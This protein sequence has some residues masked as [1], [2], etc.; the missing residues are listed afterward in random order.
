MGM[1]AKFIKGYGIFCR[2]FRSSFTGGKGWAPVIR[3]KR[4]DRCTDI[5]TY[6]QKPCK[7]QAH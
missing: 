5:I 3:P 6:E 2:P 1:I 4:N 7:M